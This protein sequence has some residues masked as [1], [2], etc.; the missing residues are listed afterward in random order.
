M[1]EREAPPHVQPADD[2]VIHRIVVERFSPTSLA[3]IFRYE[4]DLRGLEMVEASSAFAPEPGVLAHLEA[5]IADI[6]SFDH[7]YLFTPDDLADT[8]FASGI[9]LPLFMN[10]GQFLGAL[11]LFDLLSYTP[12][13]WEAV[14]D[15]ASLVTLAL[16]NQRLRETRIVADT[17]QRAVLILGDNPT[18]QQLV[19]ELRQ[20]LY[21][22]HIST[23]AMLLYGPIR[24]DRPNGPFDYLEVRGTWSRR[25]G[26]GVGLGVRI[27]L[28]QYPDILAELDEK[29]ILVFPSLKTIETRL[30]PLVRAFLRGERAHSLLLI[31]LHSG[32]RRLGLM[33]IATDRP[34]NFKRAELRNYRM[35]SEFLAM[36]AMSQ[37]IQQQ[38][39]FVQRGRAAMLDAVRDGVMMVLPQPN[40]PYV[41][42]VN[43]AFTEMFGLSQE[44]A[45]G[46]SLADVLNE[47]QIPEDVCDDLRAEWLRVPANDTAA[48]NGEFNMTLPDGLATL[49][50]WYSAPVYQERRVLGRI[51]TFHNATAERT[52]ARLR[53]NF[54]SRVSHELRTPLTS[55]HGFAQ[56][57][58]EANADSLPDLAREYLEIIVTSARH[59][60][61]LFSEIIEISEADMGTLHLNRQI[62]HLPDI[63]INAIAMLEFQYK[64]RGQTVQMDIDDDLPPVN[65]DFHRITQ[66]LSNLLSNAIRYAPPDS[67]IRV[68]TT[69]I[70]ETTQ[71]PPGAPSDVV[72]PNILVTVIDEGPGLSVQEA[73][74][75]FLPF[76]RAKEASKEPGSGLG[77]T[78]ARSIIELHRGKL[79]AEPRRRG[80]KG[81]RFHFT[82]PTAG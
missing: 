72:I 82:L 18:P 11:A 79:W 59:L 14:R 56:F 60:N 17:I 46:L 69:H 42:T 57:I 48:T 32:T 28:D 2:T 15:T 9:L 39:D 68:T 38:H 61:S 78:I 70:I 34:Y 80:R 52:A 30:D 22:P 1:A 63:V 13:E 5:L 65:V 62:A 73:E 31:A 21:G 35:V 58:L 49:I 41:L 76:Y 25:L 66:V 8:G 29:E 43:H 33:L 20:I 6:R 45:Q 47:M 23:C 75:V 54:I 67:K 74:Q 12:E 36:S 81:G 7:E 51:Y 19:N 27:Y 44:R 37:V 64:G 16:E 50:Q 53:S 71:L 24:E 26:P 77:L 3:Y 4:P 55:I 10:D 40:G